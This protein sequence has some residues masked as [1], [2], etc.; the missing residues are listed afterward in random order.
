MQALSD[1]WRRVDISLAS[2]K[3]VSA[4]GTPLAIKTT[5]ELLRITKDIL[6]YKYLYDPV[7]SNAVD[8]KTDII[9]SAWHTL[10]GPPKSVKC[11][12]DFT[13]AIGFRG[14]ETTWRGFLK[15]TIKHQL[16]FGEGWGEMIMS[17]NKIVDLD[18]LDPKKMDYAKD[19]HNFIAL[20][21]NQ[22]P[23]GYVER[24]PQMIEPI[25]R[26]EP[27]KGVILQD[28]EIFLDP[29]RILHMPMNTFGDGFYGKG[30]IEPINSVTDYKQNSWKS[31]NAFLIRLATPLLSAA[32]GDQMHNASEQTLD[33]IK[34]VLIEADVNSVL[35]FREWVK[36][37]LLQSKFPKDL[38]GSL[39]VFLNEQVA[40]LGAPKALVTG[41]GEKTNRSVL[42]NQKDILLIT[43]TSQVND[44]VDYL[45][46]KMYYPICKQAGLDVIPKIEWG[47]IKTKIDE[48]I[49]N[50]DDDNDDREPEGGGEGY[51]Q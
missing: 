46:A 39:E 51:D 47:N 21:R 44:L 34:K 38:P 8:M 24:L 50:G 31:L 16:I 32:V 27:P 19:E 11:I 41:S 35:V 10:S 25:A 30:I 2:G 36:V 29:E 37:N 6:E 17:G 40:G 49:D 9:M 15:R 33:D 5:P 1:S 3:P 18:P 48:A 22:N 7:V 26:K 4:S 23:V 43:L 20:D 13:D 45:H 14:G 12:T 42:D 28:N